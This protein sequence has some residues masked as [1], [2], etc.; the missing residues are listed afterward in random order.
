[1]DGVTLLGSLLPG[2]RELRAPLAAGYLWVF[3]CWLVLAD[4]LPEDPAKAAAP[5]RQIYELAALAG[6]VSLAVAASFA[7]YLTGILSVAVF[8]MVG[9]AASYATSY[10]F[11]ELL[12]GGTALFNSLPRRA[13]AMR[14][15]A[16]VG[17]R[18]WRIQG[19]LGQRARSRQIWNSVAWNMAIAV[20]TRRFST[21]TAFRRSVVNS[22]EYNLK[23]ALLEG[24]DLRWI[25][26]V[27]RGLHEEYLTL[28]ADQSEAGLEAAQKAVEIDLWPKLVEIAEF[29]RQLAKHLVSTAYQFSPRSLGW[30]LDLENEL[31]L[32]PARLAVLAPPAY[33]RWDRLEGEAEF[34]FAV[35]PPL[36]SLLIFGWQRSWMHPMLCLLLLAPLAVLLFLGTQNAERAQ[37]QLVA[38]VEAEVISSESFKRLISEEL[39]PTVDRAEATFIS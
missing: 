36:A 29:D 24:P 32:A 25:G 34:R 17:N 20:L 13:G 5:L 10:A 15:F 18:L 22:F 2:L 39:Y 27:P 19:Q 4:R 33:D 6:P 1:M 26:G 16:S 30:T 37:E 3:L 35:V 9:R 21:N 14:G 12:R 31:R 7:A 8:R 23:T 28:Q 11:R 38:A